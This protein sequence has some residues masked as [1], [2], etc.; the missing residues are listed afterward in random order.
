MWRDPYL[1]MLNKL[2]KAGINN[3]VD[4]TDYK[5]KIVKVNPNYPSRT[6]K[7]ESEIL[8]KR[9]QDNGHISYEFKDNPAGNRRILAD[10]SPLGHDFMEQKKAR[11]G[12]LSVGWF[13]I[14]ISIITVIVTGYYTYK[15]NDLGTRITNLERK[16]STLQQSL[17]N[18]NNQSHQYTKKKYSR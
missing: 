18:S 16:I 7:L 9:M 2:Y 6:A 17:S 13:A 11:K 3:P 12:Q 14:C 8:L 4:I 1:R 10:I 5:N 15:S